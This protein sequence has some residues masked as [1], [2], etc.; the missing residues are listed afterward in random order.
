[1]PCRPLPWTAIHRN[2]MRSYPFLFGENH[3]TWSL[4][5][6]L[7]AHAWFMQLFPQSASNLVSGFI[8]IKCHSHFPRNSILILPGCRNIKPFSTHK[9][10]KPRVA[11]SIVFVLVVMSLAAII[12]FG[13]GIQGVLAIEDIIWNHLHTVNHLLSVFMDTQYPKIRFTPLACISSSRSKRFV[14]RTQYNYL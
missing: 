4:Q 14:G 10:V 12:V 7:N 1:M 9:A 3:V 13:K 11:L 5:N 8:T 2:M 6:N